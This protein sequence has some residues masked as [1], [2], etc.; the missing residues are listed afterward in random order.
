MAETKEPE[1]QKSWRD[2]TTVSELGEMDRPSVTEW[3]RHLAG[4]GNA[5]AVLAPVPAK[6]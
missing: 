5:A 6:A 4:R 2:C 3:L 1:I